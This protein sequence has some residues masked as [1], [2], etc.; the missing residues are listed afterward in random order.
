MV[1]ALA[2]GSLADVYSTHLSVDLCWP[3]PYTQCLRV[4]GKGATGPQYAPGLISAIE[5]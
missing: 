5:V 3:L 2:A 4:Q 1:R